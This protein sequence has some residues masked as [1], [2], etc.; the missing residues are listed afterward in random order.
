MEITWLGIILFPLGVLIALLFP[1]RLDAIAIFSIPFT[2]TSLLNTASGVPITPI[3]FFGFLFIVS[4]SNEIIKNWHHIF[5]IRNDWS[6]VLL[7]LFL[8]IVVISMIMPVIIDGDLLVNSNQ[9]NNTY[10]YPV[11]LNINNIKNPFPVVF[12]IILSVCLVISIKTPQKIKYMLKIYIISG[13]FVSLWGVYQFI[14]TNIFGIEYPFYIFNNAILDTMQGYRQTFDFNGIE[15]YR[16]SSV[17]HEV[18]FFSKFILSIIPLL[19]VSIILNQPFFNIQ[20]DNIIIF[21]LMVSLMIT[22]SSSAYFG[23]VIMLGVILAMSRSFNKSRKRL[24]TLLLVTS[25]IALL[26]YFCSSTAQDMI[27]YMIISK[28][29]SG[30][31]LERTLS[32]ENSWEYFL[33]YPVLGVGWDIVTCHDLV[34]KILVST[35][36]VGLSVFSALIIYVI[37]RSMVTLKGFIYL[38]KGIDIDIFVYVLGLTISLITML[39]LG[40]F[41]GIEFYLGFFYFIISLLIAA[42][43]VS[44]YKYIYQ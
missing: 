41:S 30:S 2:A 35:G 5:D 14:S 22:T 9:L 37:R 21:V 32:V 18:S 36:F 24:T 43:R 25:A 15:L 38:S 20:I 26:I 31:A 27:D 33:E 3:I 1:K 44:T 8:F 34:V 40:L 11:S 28:L 29:D 6:L 42:N 7:I 23:L 4:Q 12:F 13:L 16:V 39:I 10:Y 19:V 17:L